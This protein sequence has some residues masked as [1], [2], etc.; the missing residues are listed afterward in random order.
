[1]LDLMTGF[2]RSEI[3]NAD[4]NHFKLQ[5]VI[6]K[7]FSYIL[8]IWKHSQPLNN[9]IRNDNV[10]SQTA[11]WPQKVYLYCLKYPCTLSG[12]VLLYSNCTVFCFVFVKNNLM[13][14]YWFSL[15]H[16]FFHIYDFTFHYNFC[17]FIICEL[18]HRVSNSASSQA[19]NQCF[20]F[21]YQFK[22]NNRGLPSS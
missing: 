11:S 7:C 14:I 13:L 4:L 15:F 17:V 12:T 9:S 6:F 2:A 19:S 18:N 10:D 8:W 3:V 1:M 5:K 16:N 22:N 21:V 20:C